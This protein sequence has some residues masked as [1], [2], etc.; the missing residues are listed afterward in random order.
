MI[1]Y[2][3]QI[4][5]FATLLLLVNQV[6]A[7]KCEKDDDCTSSNVWNVCEVD[8]GKCIHKGVFPG[9]GM[10]IGGIFVLIALKIL[11]TMAGVGGGGIVTPLCMVFFGFLT[12]DAVA[13]SA[14]ATFAATFGSFITSFRNRHPEK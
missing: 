5:T 1:S 13:V 7:A 14:F 3:L 8:T 11:C 4:I 10:E 12:K 2:N 9:L 6:L